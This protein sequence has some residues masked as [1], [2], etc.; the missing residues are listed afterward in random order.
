MTDDERQSANPGDDA[1]D[2]DEIDRMVEPDL[3][4]VRRSTW[5]FVTL[6]IAA[7]ALIAALIVSLLKPRPADVVQEIVEEP[8]AATVRIANASWLV[9]AQGAYTIAGQIENHAEGPIRVVAIRV[10]FYDE[11]HNLVESKSSNIDLPE[12]LP[13]GGHHPFSVSGPHDARYKA[14]DYRV[15][16]WN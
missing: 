1:S 7:V 3:R 4:A 13:P 2:R 8:V 5:R 15:E 11:A 14:A 9:D 16:S 6:G 10:M 12:P